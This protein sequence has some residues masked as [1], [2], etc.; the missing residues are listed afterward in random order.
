MESLPS[1]MTC[2]DGLPMSSQGW[3]LIP[4]RRFLT[5]DSTPLS[6]FLILFSSFVYFN[7]LSH[8]SKPYCT[9]ALAFN[10]MSD[11]RILYSFLRA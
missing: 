1:K 9:Y 4:L 3:E 8:S 7:A 6:F 10:V 11:D 5:L 2:S